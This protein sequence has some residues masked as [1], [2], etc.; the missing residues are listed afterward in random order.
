MPY[1]S[2]FPRFI[3]SVFIF[4]FV[5][6]FMYVHFQSGNNNSEGEEVKQR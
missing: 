4:V 5:D 2:L 6:F 1:Y 3:E